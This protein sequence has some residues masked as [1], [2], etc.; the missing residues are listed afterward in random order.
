MNIASES[1]GGFKMEK[2]G[3][4]LSIT[5]EPMTESTYGRARAPAVV[6]I[7]G[8]GE[9]DYVSNSYDHGGGGEI[10]VICA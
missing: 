2:D 1:E 10:I 6:A 8:D 3:A 9:F 5:V 4:R 7:Q